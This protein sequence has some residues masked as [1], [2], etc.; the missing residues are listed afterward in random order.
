MG[1]VVAGAGATCVVPQAASASDANIAIAIIAR[2][3]TRERANSGAIRRG[4]A[5]H[6]N[7]TRARASSISRLSLEIGKTRNGV[8][9]RVAN[10]CEELVVKVTLTST[11]TPVGVTELGVSVQVA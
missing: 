5:N 9:L 6:P 11:G 8:I 7:A 1:V 3:C 4:T 10:I 2:A